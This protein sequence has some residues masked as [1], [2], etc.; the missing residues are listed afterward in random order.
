MKGI[1]KNS[2]YG[3]WSVLEFVVHVWAGGHCHSPL[4]LACRLRDK[5]AKWGS[6]EAYEVFF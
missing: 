5:G 3:W 2:S 1:R 6:K 4:M